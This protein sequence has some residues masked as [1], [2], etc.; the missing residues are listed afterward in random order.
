[1]N[2]MA[3]ELSLSRGK[4]YRQHMASRYPEVIICGDVAILGQVILEKILIV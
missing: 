1:M 3:E 2:R 4:I